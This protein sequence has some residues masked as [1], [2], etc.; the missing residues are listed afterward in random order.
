MRQNTRACWPE[1]KV[2]HN[3]GRTFSSLM[4]ELTLVL[5]LASLAPPFLPFLPPLLVGASVTAAA[6]LT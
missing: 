2:L 4:P 6:Q 5:A 1:S 3:L